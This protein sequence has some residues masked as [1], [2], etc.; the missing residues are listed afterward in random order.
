MSYGDLSGWFVLALISEVIAVWL[1]WKIWKSS[2]YPFFKIAFSILAL[3]PIVGPV[4]VLWIGHFPSV[5]P[6]ALQDQ[7]RYRTDVLDRWRHVF[8]EKNPDERFHKWR[9]VMERK[10][11]DP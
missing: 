11:D 9:E 4:L 5:Q 8:E 2:D 1:I 7:V 6:R 3:V 10:H